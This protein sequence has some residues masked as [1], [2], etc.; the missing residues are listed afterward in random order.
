MES[1]YNGDNTR[2][3]TRRDPKGEK[4][5]ELVNRIVAMIKSVSPAY[6][7]GMFVPDAW[8]VVE[9]VRNYEYGVT[10]AVIPVIKQAIGTAID[11]MVASGDYVERPSG[12]YHRETMEE[13]ERQVLDFMAY[14]LAKERGEE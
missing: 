10:E 9:G 12:L 3:G 4:M 8:R 6:D 13:Y 2:G 5:E 11:R 7:G 14:Q 1:A